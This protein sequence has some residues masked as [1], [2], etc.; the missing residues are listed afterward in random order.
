MLSKNALI[1]MKSS[2]N[3]RKQLDIE[4]PKLEHADL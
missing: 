2:E 3:K 1:M 4:A